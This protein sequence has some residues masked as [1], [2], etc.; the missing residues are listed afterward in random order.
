MI[1]LLAPAGN[2]EAF[3][4][5]VNSG[6]DAVYMGGRQFGARAYAANFDDEELAAVV[7]EA[8]LLGVKIYVTVNT[9]VDNGELSA[10][11]AYLRQLYEI[12]IDAAIIQDAG[13]L[14]VAR[15]VAPRLPLHASTQ[16]TVHNIEGVKFL[17][18]HGITRVVLARELSLAAISRICDASPL[19]IE[20]FV[21]G[22]L[23]ISYSGQCLMSSM[24][25]G[26]SGNRGRCAQPCRLPYTLVDAAGKNA[27][28]GRDAGEYL[29][30]PKDFNTI[31]HIP[32][33][34]DAGVV[35]FKI[36][37]RMKR[38]EYVA[39]VVDSYRRAIDACLAGRGSFAVPPQDQKDMAQ[40][41]NRGFTTAYLYGK[42]GREMMSDRRPNNR[43]VRIGR[44]LEYDPRAKTAA[45]K[46]DEPLA[47][48]DIVEFW[49]KV[50]GRANTTVTAIR[51]DGRE[52]TAAPAQ[53]VATI[54][55]AGAVRPGDRVFKT[56]DAALMEK[57]RASF[58]AASPLRRIPVDAHV[59]VGEGRPLTV[60]LADDGGN[61]GSGR[62]AFLAEKAVKRPLTEE[63]L[64]AQIGR[65]G[66]TV[67]TL[68]DLHSGIDGQVMVPLSELN[69]ARRQAVDELEQA[70]LTHYARPP[71]PDGIPDLAAFLPG[72]ARGPVRKPALAV[73]VDD[74]DK[75]AAAAENGAD[76]I[77][78]GG[79]SLS[80]RPP[81]PDDYRRVLDLARG[82][83]LAVI[84]NT[85]RI[86]QDWQWPGLE[87]DLE[88]FCALAPDAVTAANLGT[89]S[90]LR[91]IPGLAVHGDWPLNI[92]NS[93]AVRFFAAAG[94]ASLSLSPELTFAQIEALAQDGSVA[95]ECLVHGRLTLMIS[96]YCVMGSFLGDLHT[97]TCTRP[98][99]QGRY[100][101]KDR[102]GETFPVAGD[103]F[104]RMH[105]LNAKELSMLPHVP[106]LARSGLARIRI[107]G[108]AAAAGEVGKIT[109]VYRELLDQG[110][111]HPLLA[112]DK[113][114]SV[115][116]EDITRGHYF[117]GVL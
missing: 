71:L 61:T 106:R 111:D 32:A 15:Q 16:M 36:E 43:G 55:V 114:K 87:A 94:L 56:F 103:Q 70:R 26:R 51:V 88:L 14:A 69:E 63:T 93:A 104:C 18:E 86:V 79:E 91:R 23:C 96:E 99:R 95:L 35:S 92:Y 50:G 22:A 60:T 27:L 102:L 57:A 4:A 45:I 117:R 37:G 85:P 52:V 90:R 44:V 76:I 41:F 65:L 54:P 11:A 7:R 72:P 113:I 53:A 21:H 82:H 6:A 28:A 39:I 48:G 83:G 109:R 101:L 84:F 74:P 49:V 3:T 115:E 13:V 97:G 98:C 110:E 81:L 100:L 75:A 68:R 77:M 64:A 25:G 2:R 89:L 105:I 107:E 1:E 66:T 9:L 5:A 108:K 47:V 78:F 46:L 59:A 33:L 12:G 19:E 80:S 20:T 62:T 24:I 31:E 42:Q 73:N 116:H 112:G 67:F 29:L 30:S 40:I 8:H 10:L 38:A 58:D 17:A 34:I